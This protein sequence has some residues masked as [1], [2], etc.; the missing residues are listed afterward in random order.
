MEVYKDN[1]KFETQFLCMLPRN[2]M[3]LR[4]P[5]GE[6][7]KTGDTIQI[8]GTNAKYTCVVKSFLNQKVVVKKVS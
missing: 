1:N 4:I 8:H 3:R 6:V 7:W 2:R 5:K